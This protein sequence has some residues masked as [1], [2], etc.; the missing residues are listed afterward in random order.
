MVHGSHC[1]TSYQSPLSSVVERVTR[2]DEVG[3]SIQPAGIIFVVVSGLFALLTYFSH[4]TILINYSVGF[5]GIPCLAV[6]CDSHC[7]TWNPE[8]F[9]SLTQNKNTSYENPIKP[10]NSALSALTASAVWYCDTHFGAAAA[11][12]AILAVI[13]QCRSVHCRC[14]VAKR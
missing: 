10:L 3:C 6:T 2:N 5:V 8:L 1:S 11:S 14:P 13:C 12:W 7:K 9:S 4:L